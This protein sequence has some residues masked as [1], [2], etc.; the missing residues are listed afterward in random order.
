MGNQ[1][2][3]IEIPMNKIRLGDNARLNIQN[4]E[5][6]DLMQSIKEH[7]IMQAPVVTASAD[8]KGYYDL[9]AGR[10]RFLAASKLGWTR[11]KCG[12]V[13]SKDT[14]DILFKNL[15]EN[16]QRSN[17]SLVEAGRYIEKL[18]TE[19][20]G[21]TS[22]EIA[23]R[24]GVTKNYVDTASRAYNEVPKEFQ[25][26]L[27]LMRGNEKPKPGQIPITTAKAIINAK[28]SYRLTAAQA[29][30]LF[31][32]AKN[33]DNFDSQNVIK[34]A[35][36]M[37]A[38]KKNFTKE[39]KK[40]KTVS[41]QLHFDQAEYDAAYQKHIVNGPFKSWNEVVAAKLQGQISGRINAQTRR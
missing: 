14:K 1:P 19:G 8:K 21:M 7:G 34:Y 18:R 10:R 22:A 27:V 25:K 36:A 12:V 28:K 30:R 16:I 9:V 4:Q 17:I 2:D 32:A 24:L 26:S 37:K 40:M 5:L 31:K 38:G 41:V 6:V 13:E 33:D 23:V 39:V 29:S 11:L 3:V 15:T 20:D 35:Q